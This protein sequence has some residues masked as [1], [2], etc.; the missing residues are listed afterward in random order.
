MTTKQ[1]NNPKSFENTYAYLFFSL[2]VQ[3]E[4]RYIHSKGTREFLDVVL[5]TSRNREMSLSKDTECWRAQL[6]SAKTA[7]V[8]NGYGV[9]LFQKDIPYS[10]ERMQPLPD[11][12]KEGRANPKGI[13]F[14][15]LSTNIQTAIQEI[16]PWLGTK[17]SVAHFRTVR[18]L[19]IVDCSKN[20][21]KLDG[22]DRD[23]LGPGLDKEETLSDHEI[24]EYV[25]SWI[26]RAFSM[27][28]DPS[29]DKADY[30]PTQILAEL[31][32][33]E[34]YDGIIYNSL[35]AEGKNVALFDLDSAKL[36]DCKLYRVINIPP[37]KFQGVHQE[38]E[39]VF[40]EE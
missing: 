34:G 27:P 4:R 25:W 12:A 13:P 17:I 23:S 21:H 26:D 33:A 39:S 38:Y 37:F 10:P 30:V 36:S 14:L 8:T 20:I 9:T 29:D 16:R 31:F 7:G 2:T 3:T 28:I 40:A 11:R 24:E 1:N 6:G 15:Y 35:L 19:K 5:A 32:R 22:A 18:D